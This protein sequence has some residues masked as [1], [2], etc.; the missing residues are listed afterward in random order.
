MDIFIRPDDVLLFRDG[1]AFSAG[2]AGL[3]SGIFPPAP[4]PFYGAIRSAMLSQKNA[5]FS[6]PASGDGW[7]FDASQALLDEVGSTTSLGAMA[8]RRFSMARERAGQIEQLFAVPLDLLIQVNH[9]GGNGSHNVRLLQPQRMPF[10]DMSNLPC[11]QYLWS[12]AHEMDRYESAGELLTE[13]QFQT[14]LEGRPPVL[15]DPC[16][17]RESFFTAEPRTSVKINAETG[18]ASEG[19]LFTVEFTRVAKDIGFALSLEDASMLAQQ[20]A[21][22]LGGEGRSAQ[23]T[24]C[25][26]KALNKE[27]ICA[28][29]KAQEGRFKLVFL[30]P[31]V[32]DAGWVKSTWQGSNATLAG[33]KVE[34]LAA[35]VGRYQHIGGWDL[36]AGRPRLTR[37]AV[38]AGSVYFFQSAIDN[39]DQIFEHLFEQSV[40]DEPDDVKLGL[41]IAT[42]GAWPASGR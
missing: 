31:A 1:R 8:I 41:G 40:S 33:C 6:R 3:A 38:P 11:Q 21:L 10:A 29:V 16:Q 19:N 18:T 5:V 39:I 15:A 35:S 32:L 9:A 24:Q 13:S 26:L 23:Y 27:K 14:Y 7:T 28:Q 42:I 30:T 12:Q 34:L 4:V 36:A 17:E 25:S 20:G 37:R 2:E 22:R